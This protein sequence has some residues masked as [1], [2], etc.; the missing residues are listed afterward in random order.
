MLAATIDDVVDRLDD[1]LRRACATGDR[2]GY[3]AAL[4]NR[5][6]LRVRDGIR[7]GEFEDNARM[8]RLDVVFANR[9]LEAHDLYVRGERPTDPWLRAFDAAGKDG[10][11]VIQHLL[12]G[13]TAHIVLDL[14]IAAATV[15]PGPAIE[16]LRGDFFRINDVLAS[17][18]GTVEGELVEIAG[19]WR[20]DLGHVLGFMERAAHGAERSAASLMMDGA[21]SLAW[22]FADRLA[23]ASTDA[24]DAQI[25]LQA[26]QATL[27]QDTILVEAPL[28]Q[29]LAHGGERDI[30][31]NI[32]VLARGELPL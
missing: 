7:R 27:M 9:Y 26:A 2:R 18:V 10:L 3:F 23:R 17:L 28:I 29:L 21:R 14:G 25:A 15:A 13:M 12:L 6:T 30:A 1:I 20:P 22:S 24:R 16:G 8:E 11:F 4:Y 32:R 19:D 5:V 31:G